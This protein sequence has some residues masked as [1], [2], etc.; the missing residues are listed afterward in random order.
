MEY[1]VDAIPSAFF[2]SD[3]RTVAKSAAEV[4]KEI[5]STYEVAQAWGGQ[6]IASYSITCAPGPELRELA[7]SDDR[8]GD[9]S[10]CLFLVME[11]PDGYQEREAA[12]VEA[13]RTAEAV[14]D[15]SA[16]SAQHCD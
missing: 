4:A 16:A 9:P 15:D 10:E 1:H 14:A 8:S 3:A 7:R 5:A 6:V 13:R 2:D 11:L 12:E